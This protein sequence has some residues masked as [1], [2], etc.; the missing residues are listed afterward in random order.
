MLALASDA[1]RRPAQFGFRLG[2]Q[3]AATDRVTLVVSAAGEWL[4]RGMPEIAARAI[5]QYR[6]A[7]G[8]GADE[9]VECT[10]IRADRRATFRCVA[11]VERPPSH[12]ADGLV[13][14]GDYVAGRY[15][16]TLEAAVLS[17]E[18]AAQSLTRA[19]ES[20]NRNVNDGFTMRE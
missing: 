6:D 4:A 7:F 18:S 20:E 1:D 10:A 17:G 12:I 16:A 5:A 15:P 14:A 11:G 2:T 9:H 3:D 8:I 19:T 13:A